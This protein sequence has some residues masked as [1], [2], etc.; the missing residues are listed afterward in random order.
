[1]AGGNHHHHHHRRT[2]RQQ[3]QQQQQQQQSQPSHS[4]PP[5]SNTGNR[6]NTKRF[7]TI[8]SSNNNNNSSN[9]SNNGSTTTN[10]RP[11]DN[12]S[13]STS[14]FSSPSDT[15][16]QLS[17]VL[18]EM[19][20]FTTTATTTTTRQ[21]RMV[22]MFFLTL[23]LCSVVVFVS[24]CLVMGLTVGMILS[25]H[26]FERQSPVAA[27]VSD[28]NAY[29]TPQLLYSKWN[30]GGPLS[31]FSS[32]SLGAVKVTLVDAD[33][34]ACN[35]IHRY[36]TDT[37]TTSTTTTT[38][39]DTSL[40]LGKVITTTD[41]GQLQVLMVVQEELPIHA[42][43]FDQ[44]YGKN[45]EYYRQL[46]TVPAATPTTHSGG[47]KGIHSRHH[48]DDS[49]ADDKYSHDTEQ[50]HSNNPTNSTSTTTNSLGDGIPMTLEQAER[51]VPG[52]TEYIK[53]QPDFG[54][55]DRVKLLQ[56]TLCESDGVTYG[57]DDW[58]TLRA[59]VQEA[60]YLAAE[61]FRRW[62]EY[63]ANHIVTV[64]QDDT[65]YY[66][67]DVVFTI[68]P[69]TTLTSRH[70]HPYQYPFSFPFPFFHRR[71]NNNR[72]ANS[73]VINSENIVLQCDNCI[74]D[75]KATHHIAFGV[76]ARN[77]LIRGVTFRGA[78]SSSLTFHHDGAEVTLEDC[79]WINNN[80][81]NNNK[82]NNNNNKNNNRAN[83]NMKLG[84]VADI[85]S[86]SIVTFYRCEIG[87]DKTKTTTTTTTNWWRWLCTWLVSS[88]IDKSTNPL[89]IRSSL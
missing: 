78:T 17:L 72:H 18:M 46:D 75:V 12:G 77:V 80:N 70:H 28:G 22:C 69:N 45:G 87:F 26:Y 15:Y 34:A 29:L 47:G 50:E 51:L 16:H 83:T 62:N 8:H 55:P 19:E 84:G 88:S 2:T 56:P 73:I 37:A 38:M 61:R 36:S 57:Y 32:S 33:I 39:T 79:K 25:V 68:C 52:Y 76:N 21:P 30:T 40:E 41:S 14:S 13:S 49:N 71:N 9:N 48:H 1:M 43:T 74:I 24:S 82:K 3:Q 59:A 4:T 11:N 89:S 44:S 63:F 54:N 42:T 35:V 7:F 85:N 6:N 66:E 65:L 64:F 27:I 86:T 20:S 81:N 67:Q 58:T 5:S 23:L 53:R 10:P 60:N 31:L